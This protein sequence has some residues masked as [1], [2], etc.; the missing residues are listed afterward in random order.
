MS[1]GIAPAA[2]RKSLTSISAAQFVSNRS[3]ARPLLIR[4]WTTTDS[5]R[6]LYDSKKK[7]SVDTETIGSARDSR[8]N[9][10]DGDRL[11]NRGWTVASRHRQN[12][13]NGRRSVSPMSSP[14]S[15][16]IQNFDGMWR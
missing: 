16:S 9:R 2:S 7:K 5:D 1:E 15:Y 10:S 12:C 3:Q 14:V 13:W 11:F 8:Q 6:I 4:I